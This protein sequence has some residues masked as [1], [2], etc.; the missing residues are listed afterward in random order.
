MSEEVLIVA[1]ISALLAPIP[2][3]KRFEVMGK[4]V[5]RQVA[6]IRN[7]RESYSN[8]KESKHGSTGVVTITQG[9]ASARGEVPYNTKENIPNLN[10]IPLDVN[11]IPIPKP[12]QSKAETMKIDNV[13]K[14]VAVSRALKMPELSDLRSEVVQKMPELEKIVD[15]A[16]QYLKSGKRMN[17]GVQEREFSRFYEKMLRVLRT[18]DLELQKQ[19]NHMTSELLKN[20]FM[21]TGFG[22]I[23][24]AEGH[25]NSLVI[26]AGDE[27]TFTS[28]FAEVDAR[29]GITLDTKGF[30]EDSCKKAVDLVI[31]KL[32][33][34]G[35]KV[36]I[37]KRVFHGSEKGG[38]T[39]RKYET[40]FN[41]LTVP[42]KTEVK[43]KKEREHT[44]K[45]RFRLLT[46]RRVD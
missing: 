34:K 46:S 7:T 20:A 14:L 27:K 38:E 16:I 9:N 11:P 15:K 28:I 3:I 23:S 35:V 43:K 45:K 2:S 22:I 18:K 6:D 13:E 30:R 12:I 25:G 5:S 36:Q 19:E 39:A 24:Q 31:S 21:E 40:L 44:R 32:E 41:P 26:R 8:S 10:L 42:E 33:E 17:S 1:C 4:E 29:K 37:K